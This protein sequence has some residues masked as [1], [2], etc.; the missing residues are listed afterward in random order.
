MPA[1]VLYR[2]MVKPKGQVVLAGLEVLL[3]R[4]AIKHI[5]IK[6]CPPD[7]RVSISAPLRT[8]WPILERV[9]REKLAWI[10]D[11]QAGISRL[12]A[13]S[14][15]DLSEGGLV[16]HLGRACRLRL[17]EASR[18]GIVLAEADIMEMGLKPGAGLEQ[19]RALLDKWRREQLGVMLAAMREAWEERLG[20]R[21]AELR[22]KRMRTRW[23][24]CNPRARRI[25][26][27]LELIK[28]PPDCI[29]YVLVHEL[30]HLLEPTHN[31]CFV[32]LLDKFMPDW[33]ERKKALIA[34]PL[35]QDFMDDSNR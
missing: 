16:W 5:H 13:S 32:R 3:V 34:R 7:G 19:A 24:S 27:T 4:K 2:G 14:G 6:V 22:V 20:V 1:T 9:I 18:P 31:A 35:W 28:R 21:A 30:L 26:L 8:S 15:Q 23:G 17:V 10:R 11:R 33:R 29:E 25:W 12:G